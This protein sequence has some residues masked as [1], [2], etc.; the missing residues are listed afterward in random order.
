M[1][2]I[3][4]QLLWVSQPTS[5]LS[6]EESPFFVIDYAIPSTDT[7]TQAPTMFPTRLPTIVTTPAVSST[8]NDDGG[9]KDVAGLA[10]MYWIIIGV[11]GGVSVLTLLAV[12][13]YYCV[14]YT[15]SKKDDTIPLNTT[16]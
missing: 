16:V 15:K 11:L 7:P 3:T 2:D 14:Q 1:V 8:N 4:K 13:G 10:V 5:L 6:H 12:G 9:S